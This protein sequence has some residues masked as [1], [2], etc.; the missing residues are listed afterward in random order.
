M[1]N[2]QPA[3]EMDLSTIV[4]KYLE[5]AGQFGRPVHLSKFG[6]SREDTEKV[7]SALD[8][9][10]QISRYLLLSRER[11]EELTSYP[12]DVRVIVISGFEV[13]HLTFHADIQKLL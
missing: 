7:I 10:Y 4:K 9:D 11:D 12:Q 5:L 3:R 2:G 1:P 6:L 8:E 13:S